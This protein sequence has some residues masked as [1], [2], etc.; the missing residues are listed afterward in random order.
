MKVALERPQQTA[1][2][3]CILQRFGHQR[4]QIAPS[5]PALLQKRNGVKYCLGSLKNSEAVR[6]YIRDQMSA[7]V[8]LYHEDGVQFQFGDSVKVQFL[9]SGREVC[10]VGGTTSCGKRC[11]RRVLL[12]D[13]LIAVYDPIRVTPS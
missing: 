11:G 5:E 10:G 6:Q 13:Q 12:A 8:Q 2:F 4:T 3:E 9:P 7:I 1:T